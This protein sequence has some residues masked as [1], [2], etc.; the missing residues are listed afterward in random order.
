MFV[1]RQNSLIQ[2]DRLSV[3]KVGASASQRPFVPF[4]K[5]EVFSAEKVIFNASLGLLVGLENNAL[6]SVHLKETTS[7][8]AKKVQAFGCAKASTT[9]L[10]QARWCP[11]LCAASGQ[12][13]DNSSFSS[14]QPW[15]HCEKSS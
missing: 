9:Q 3:C 11:A 8:C 13:F 7:P 4:I 12:G 15:D 14:C 2:T 1:M 6:D 5:P 10:C